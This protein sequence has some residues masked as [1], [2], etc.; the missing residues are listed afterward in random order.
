MGVY[1]D[2]ILIVS[3]VLILIS[4][5]KIKKTYTNIDFIKRLVFTPLIYILFIGVPITLISDPT[6]ASLD[7]IKVIFRGIKIIITFFG[8]LAL[9]NIY[10]ENYPL[11]YFNKK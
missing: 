4:E 5:K 2:S 8:A 1:L 10:I 3:L 9:V 6:L 7:F 11:N